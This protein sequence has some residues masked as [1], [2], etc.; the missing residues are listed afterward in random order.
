MQNKKV[1]AVRNPQK[2]PI[3]TYGHE[4]LGDAGQ[5]GRS[6]RVDQDLVLGDG[7]HQHGDGVLWPEVL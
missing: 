1:D 5:H 3:E 4:C 2:Y 7:E 6:Q